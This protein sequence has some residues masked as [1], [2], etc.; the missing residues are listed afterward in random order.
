M[1][2]SVSELTVPSGA[3][4]EVERRF[5]AR[6]KAVDGADGFVGFELL[7]PV[8]GGDR[9]VVITRWESAEQHARWSATRKP[10][11]HADDVR[12]GMSVQVSGFEV[13]DLGS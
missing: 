6:R 10:G 11:A 3:A 1:Y 9:Y 4:A 2:V 7:R 8:D 12:G 13:V 5:A